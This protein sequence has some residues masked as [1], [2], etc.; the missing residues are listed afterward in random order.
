VVFLSDNG[1]V[2]WNYRPNPPAGGGPPIRLAADRFEFSNAPLRAMKGTA[3]EGGIRIPMIV[4]WPG[5]ARLG[6]VC[7]TPVH[8]VDILPTFF[9]MAG[10]RA[11]RNHFLDGLSLL[12]LLRRES[13]PS[14]PLFWYMPFYDLRWGATPC[15]VIREGDFKLIES[16]G[17]HVDLNAGE[18][19]LGQRLELF[20]LREDLGERVNLAASAPRRAAELQKKL[21]AWIRSAGAEIPRPNPR[22]DPQRALQETR[23]K[24]PGTA[25]A[26]PAYRAIRSV[27][28]SS[29]PRSVS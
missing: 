7:E 3:Y 24:P 18:Y 22:Y 12:P 2:H 9:E 5:V 13:F 1:G 11:P 28:W 19:R 26:F 6:A 29:T 14:R 23:D 4:R 21:H 20:N 25:R 10:A 17:D 15:A 8:A 16:F 27:R